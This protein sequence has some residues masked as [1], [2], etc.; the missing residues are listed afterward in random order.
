MSDQISGNS[1]LGHLMKTYPKSE[2]EY[3]CNEWERLR[4]LALERGE[5]TFEC[6]GLK[7][8]TEIVTCATRKAVSGYDS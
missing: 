5:A 3:A 2:G 8:T 1:L 6:Y 7:W 4:L